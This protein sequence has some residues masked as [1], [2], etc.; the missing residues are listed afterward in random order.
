MRN[1]SGTITSAAAN[2]LP[3][4][5]W[6]AA[7]QSP[8]PEFSASLSA[9]YGNDEANLTR[10][11]ALVEHGL[12]CFLDLYGNQP[13][14][15]LRAPGR[16]NL[17]GMHVDTHGGWLNLMTH[18]REVVVIAAPRA[19][20]QFQFHNADPGYSPVEVAAEPFLMLPAFLGAWSAFLQSEL[21]CNH[22]QERRGHWGLYLL[23]CVLRAHHAAPGR[24]L[25]GMNAVVA[26]DLPCG[27]SL[28]SSAALCVAV[29]LA[30]LGRNEISLADDALILAARDAEWFTGA[31]TGTGDQTAVVCGR[32]GQILNVAVLTE[33]FELSSARHVPFP[34]AL[35]LL[36][37]NSF[38]ERSLSG[39]DLLNYTRNRF[40]YS[41]ALDVLRQEMLRAGFPE[42]QV[43]HLDRL[44]KMTPDRFESRCDLYSLLQRVPETISL[45]QLRHKYELPELD[46]HYQKYF[47]LISQASRPESIALRGPLLFALTESERARVFPGLLQAGAFEAAGACML[48]G[49]DGDRVSWGGGTPWRSM[50]VTNDALE[51]L[52]VANTPL[53]QVPGV[54]GASSL[55]L[56]ALVDCAMSAGALGACLTGAGIAGSVLAL[57]PK[58]FTARVQHAVRTLLASPVYLRLTGRTKSLTE[59]QLAEAAVI[60]HAP[61]GAGK[62]P[63]PC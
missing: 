25:L 50:E 10:R 37:I 30:I 55:I 59:G 34:A 19:D 33:D 61:V 5:A 47:G 29:L 41:I 27:A 45:S 7:C 9:I 39:N 32:R 46:A 21:V 57:C 60:N 51:R 11:T 44:S 2:V 18:Q 14:Q 58:D 22:I 1:D 54:Y 38:T 43:H 4:A 3:A 52:A 15:V 16:V 20:Q 56:D 6:L 23:G 17:R 12:H 62:L 28:S 53:A 42:E 48:L 63:L 31:R 35:D 26:S 8:S 24:P 49:H 36:I 40:A 13:V